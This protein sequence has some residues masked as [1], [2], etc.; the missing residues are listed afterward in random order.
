VPESLVLAARVLG[1]RGLRGEVK[2]RVLA[3]TPGFFGSIRRIVV[4]K[5]GLQDRSYT[6]SGT[7]ENPGGTAVIRLVGIE[8]RDQALA[9]K[10]AELLVDRADL[11]PAPADAFYYFE[12][13][14]LRVED[15]QGR[16]LGHVK[17]ILPV[18]QG[19]IYV[20][21]APKDEIL[22]PSAGDFVRSIEPEQGRMVVRLIDGMEPQ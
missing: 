14:G 3:D 13:E 1:P 9:L 10:G 21:A 19:E 20:V 15:E 7:R 2:I 6:V 16:L 11:P 8:D 12:I 4:R 18:P 5:P 22:I 17:E